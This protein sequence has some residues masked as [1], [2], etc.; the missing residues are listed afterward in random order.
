MANRAC[1]NVIVWKNATR[2][3]RKMQ[4][5]II[6]LDEEDRDKGRGTIDTR[7]QPIKYD[8]SSLKGEEEESRWLAAAFYSAS[9][10]SH[11]WA[12]SFSDVAFIFFIYSSVKYD[13]M[14][15]IE[16]HTVNI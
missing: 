8:G 5:T 16:V 11:I 2:I 13:L 4:E 3:L 12:E 15:K 14:N 10:S 9:Q 7:S 6:F 1:E